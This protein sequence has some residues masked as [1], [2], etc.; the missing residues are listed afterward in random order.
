MTANTS[1]EHRQLFHTWIEMWRNDSCHHSDATAIVQRCLAETGDPAYFIEAPPKIKADLL[2][3]LRRFRKT[4]NYRVSYAHTPYSKDLSGEARAAISTLIRA[5]LVPETFAEVAP[6]RALFSGLEHVKGGSQLLELVACDH[7]LLSAKL[8]SLGSHVASAYEMS[9]LAKVCIRVDRHVR[10]Y[11]NNE[12]YVDTP[13][14]SCVADFSLHSP[15]GF[16][17]SPCFRLD[18]IASFEVA[19]FQR[20]GASG[21]EITL[22]F[23]DFDGAMSCREI[24]LDRLEA[25]ELR[26]PG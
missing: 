16:Y 26:P 8:I 2:R 5:G 7:S 11:K 23:G 12:F 13:I 24:T 20:K 19:P 21:Y 15:M 10:E 14:R 3:D 6:V 18:Y 9:Q 17:F 25:L 4:G 22:D 1:G